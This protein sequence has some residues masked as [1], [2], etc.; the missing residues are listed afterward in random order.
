MYTYIYIY[1]YRERESEIQRERARERERDSHSL[2]YY[3]W[4]PEGA[5]AGHAAAA[6]AGPRQKD[7]FVIVVFVFSKQAEYVNKHT[8]N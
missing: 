2:L 8:Y 6:A 1:I 3:R 7:T 4:G 5:T